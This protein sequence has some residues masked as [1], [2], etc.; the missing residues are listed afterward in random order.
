MITLNNIHEVAVK[1]NT[2]SGVLIKIQDNYFI[3]TAVHCIN[4]LGENILRSFDNKCNYKIEGFFFHKD[5]TDNLE[6]FESDIVLLK[7][8]IKEDPI[9]VEAFGQNISIG[10][11]VESYG[12]PNKAEKDGMPLSGSVI[13]WNNESTSIKTDLSYKGPLTDDI[14]A[15]LYIDGWSGS[16]VFNNKD[17]NLYLI[18]I[19]KRI[20]SKDHTYQD[21]KLIPIKLILEVIEYNKLGVFP[22]TISKE[23]VVER[24]TFN[25]YNSVLSE[26]EPNIQKL[27]NI[28]SATINTSFKPCDILKEHGENMF[29][30]AKKPKNINTKS[31]WE[32]WLLFLIYLHLLKPNVSLGNYIINID[33]KETRINFLFNEQD[34]RFSDLIYDL[35]NNENIHQ[36]KSDIFLFNN[37]KGNLKPNILST[38]QKQ[39]ILTDF[40]SGNSWMEE[41]IGEYKFGC[42]HI[43]SL[44]DNIANSSESDLKE[45]KKSIKDKIV[46]VLENVLW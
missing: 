35:L 34:K 15:K 37:I 28:I 25:D 13:K 39:N 22:S 10:D 24:L 30:P 19:L 16:G 1:V 32:G 14:D 4:E 36:M 20:T 29:I 5:R 21:I 17:N 43:A 31:L 23:T 44:T 3:T 27:F 6:K 26:F 8:I 12:F 40:S 45:L 9:Y 46:K 38:K 33:D 11:T 7:V 18:G 42:L 41:V 2:G